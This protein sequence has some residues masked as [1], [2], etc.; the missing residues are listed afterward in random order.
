MYSICIQLRKP[1][2]VHQLLLI[3]V[4]INFDNLFRNLIKL[5]KIA[6]N[7]PYVTYVAQ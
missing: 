2:T 1:I 6:E 3:I 5:R 4:F 7:I